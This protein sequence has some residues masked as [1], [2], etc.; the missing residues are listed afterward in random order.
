MVIGGFSSV[1]KEFL[2]AKALGKTDPTGDGKGLHSLPE[3]SYYFNGENLVK[4][5]LIIFYLS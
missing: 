1:T 3:N 5:V 4:M 2:E